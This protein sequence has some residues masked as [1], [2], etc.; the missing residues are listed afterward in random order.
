[1]GGN[2]DKGFCSVPATLEMPVRRPSAGQRAEHG[3]RHKPGRRGNGL[4]L[5]SKDNKHLNE[6]MG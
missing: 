5:V 2:T 4:D 1:M 3:S 6:S